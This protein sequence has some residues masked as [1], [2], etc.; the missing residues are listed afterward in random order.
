MKSTAALRRRQLDQVLIKYK[1]MPEIPLGYIREIRNALGMSSYQLAARLGVSQASAMEMEV[2]EQSGAIS[3][4][5]LRRAAQALGC[6]V[7]YSLVPETSLQHSMLERAREL[8]ISDAGNVFRSM[9]LEQQS[10][11][12]AEQEELI[13]ELTQEWLLKIR[14][15][16]KEHDGV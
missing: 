7:V 3:L 14:E 10:T 16:W 8:A 13:G 5:T 1:D 2:N 6:K 9:G 4:K 15:L 11:T 12:T